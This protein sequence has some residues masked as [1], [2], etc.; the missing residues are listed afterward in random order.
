[1]IR[2]FPLAPLLFLVSAGPDEW[3]PE[4]GFSLLFNG[5]DLTGWKYG[6]EA[7][8]GKTE[9]EDRRF[10]VVDGAIVANEK[11]AA[12]KG[13]I[14]NLYTA[15]SFDRDF[16]V[17]LEF[18]AGPRSDSGV[19]VRGPQLQVRDFFRLNQ[20]K[21]LTKFR[22]DDWNELDITVKAG[23]VTTTV[24]GKAV[25]AKDVLEVTVKDGKPDARL[26]GLPVDV[27]SIQVS[28]GPVADCLLNGEP[29]SPREMS[30][31]ARGP[32]GLQAESG[33][34]EFR[35]LRVRQAP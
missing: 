7:L 33:K 31:P 16:Q 29:L 13:G 23:V 10:Q 21:Q 27:S 4:E 8:D 14:K 22:N 12:G 11:D 32:I 24:N 18:R 25:G 35:R 2:G 6:S 3:K 28:V 26:N 20:Q 15:A 1:M 30:V 19:Y 9:T 34:F 17:K 5:K